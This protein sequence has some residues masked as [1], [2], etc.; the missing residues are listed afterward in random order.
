MTQQQQRERE[1][2]V[3]LTA[4]KCMDYGMNAY[5]RRVDQQTAEYNPLGGTGT[6]ACANCVF[7]MSPNGCT[8]VEDWPAPISPTGLSK[9][10]TALPAQDDYPPMRVVIVEEEKDMA[11]AAPDEKG[12]FDRLVT[13]V[14]SAFSS[15][16]A[17]A[18]TEG[19][20]TLTPE[21]ATS[22]P[23]EVSA[24]RL[25]KEASGTLRWVMF[26][27]NNFKDR[28][29]EIFEEAAHKEF[30]AYLD[31]T[32][33][34]PE[35]W[36]W[37]TPGTRWGQA[38]F[39]DYD[40]GFLV[41]SGFVDAG[42]EMLAEALAAEAKEL[43][44]S[45]GY[46][47]AKADEGTGVYRWYR[48]FEVSPL[49][50]V[51]AANLWTGIDVIREEKSMNAAKRAWLEGKLGKAQVDEI[52]AGRADLSKALRDRGVDYKEMPAD[53]PA[54]S[55]SAKE[56]GEAAV[57]ALTES[58]AFK[59]LQG[60]LTG[61][62]ANSDQVPGL[63][64]RLGTVEAS[65][66]A[67]QKSDDEKIAAAITPRVMVGAGYRA[68][69]AHDTAVGEGDVDARLKERVPLVDPGFLKSMQ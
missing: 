25:Y 45:H 4:E 49:P 16:G 29:G 52:E 44:V 56:I 17:L 34:Y 54:P 21:G 51:A 46:Y 65:I 32:K 55:M 60:T 53:D 7:F 63:V 10:W 39:A 66:K 36:L 33:D 61:I 50:L 47:Y 23:S 12:F 42:K 13:A 59:E 22:A 48:S 19:P 58:P 18:G 67:L 11:G 24:F 31:R 2:E 27:S 30:V 64:E 43:G 40:N 5:A 26:A 6:Q 20:A 69:Q 38:D 62:K 9:Y 68:T 57:K 28:E 1:R 41:V 35:A 8:V 14:K 15:G 3:Q 37:H